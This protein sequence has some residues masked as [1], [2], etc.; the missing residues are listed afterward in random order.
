MVQLL[1]FS[2]TTNWF[3]PL[4][5]QDM[6]TVGQKISKKDR[7]MKGRDNTMIGVNETGM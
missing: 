5:K 2:S 6:I 4:Q 1:K 3:S 7:K